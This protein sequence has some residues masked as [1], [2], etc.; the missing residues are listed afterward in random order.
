MQTRRLGKT[1]RTVSEIG[2]GAWAI[3]GGWGETEDTESLAA[4]HAAGLARTVAREPRG[5]RRRSRAAPLPVFRQRPAELFFEQAQRHDVGI[6]VRVPLASGLLTGKFSRDSSF[7]PDDHRSF[8]RQGERFDVGETFA[9]VDFE[10]GVD[11]VE[12][13]NALY[14]ER[15]APQVHHRW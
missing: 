3:G 11:V 7:G 6:V 12:E 13:L 9:G 4:M 15:I 8:N 5:R 14:R 10:R 2:F 1:N